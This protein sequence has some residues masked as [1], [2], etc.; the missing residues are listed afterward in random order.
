MVDMKKRTIS[1]FFIVLILTISIAYG[2]PLFAIVMT[3]C[4]ILGLHEFIGVKNKSKKK[5]LDFINLIS[6][7]SLLLITLN[8]T[9]FSI[10]N[11]SL[12]ILPILGLAIPLIIYNDNDKYNIND[13][14]Y[15]IASI[16]I[17]GIAF[18]SLI[19]FREKDICLCIYIFLISFMT[20][21][22]AYIGG[23]LIGKHKLTSISP[24][25]T[26]EGSLIGTVMA[27]I[28]GSCFYSILINDMGNI[29]IIF[30]SLLLSVVS[31]FGDLFFSS[32][33]RY[34]D[35]KDYSNLIPGHGGI[36]DRLDSVIFVTLL[37]NLLLSIF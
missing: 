37:L 33:K 13:C 32:I 34:Y 18:N 17:L 8:N 16:F 35:K 7:I 1:A 28:I 4:S 36:L 2:N 27:T 26:I 29:S 23:M 10:D 24:K 9:F 12:L 19:L 20:D 14:L 6:Y 25:K 15:L 22:Y 5:K 3:L 21:T 31:Q 11:I 30:I